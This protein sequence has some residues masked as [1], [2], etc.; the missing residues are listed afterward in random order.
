MENITKSRRIDFT[1]LLTIAFLIILSLVVLYS[2]ASSLFPVYFLYIFL[3]VIV[4]FVFSGIDFD[5]LSLFSKHIYI[6][7]IIFLLLPLLIGQVTRGAI[8]WIPIGELTIQPAEIVRPFL[9]VFFA[10]YLTTESPNALRLVKALGL[11]ALPAFLIVIQP[12]LGVAILTVIGFLGVLF[13][14]GLKRKHLFLGVLVFLLILPVSWQMMKDYQQSRII[15]FIN[16]ADDPLGAGYNS[17][18]STISVGSGKIFG[19]GLG[20]G[21]QTQLAFLPERHTDFVFASVS[22]ELG[23]V[24][25]AVLLSLTFFI[26]WKL[27]KILEF[28]KNVAARAFISGFFL[29][30]FAQVLIHAGMNMGLLPITGVPFPLVSAGGSSLIATMAGLGMVLGAKKTT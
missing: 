23:L 28:A 2:I 29:M 26:L 27:I 6:G 3:A 12:S 17:I 9:L 22:E 11:L 13:A 18:Q 10:N 1:L 20:K 4:F 5:I 7:S 24:G 25:V 21:V 15:S 30:Y 16:P 14:A 19:R 8:R